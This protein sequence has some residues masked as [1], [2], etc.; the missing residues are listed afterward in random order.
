MIK[1]FRWRSLFKSACL[2][3]AAIS[4]V[5]SFLFN[6]KWKINNFDWKNCYTTNMATHS[7][8]TYHNL[9]ET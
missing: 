3:S 2:K 8:S 1:F 9:T 4:K 6:V 5:Y 7:D